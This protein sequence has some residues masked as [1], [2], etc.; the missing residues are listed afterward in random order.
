MDQQF[1]VQEVRAWLHSLESDLQRLAERLDPLLAEQRRLEER[2]TLLRGLLRSFDQVDQDE[3]ETPDSARAKGSVAQYVIDRACE[4]LRDEGR[5]L[6]INDLHAR[7]LERGFTI[8]GAGKPANLIVHL[9]NAAEIAAP[10]RG[11]YGLTAD[12]IAVHKPRKRKRRKGAQT[13]RRR[14]GGS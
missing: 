10:A 3:R 2:Q 9:R 7:F 14:G 5:P 12:G 11:I 8:P 6:H 4:I 13:S 1:T